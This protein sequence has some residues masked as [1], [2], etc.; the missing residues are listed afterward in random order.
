[1]IILAL[2]TDQENAYVAIYDGRK[3]LSEI[4]WLA[5]RELSTTLFAKID[6]LLN[7][8]NLKLHDIEGIIG[9]EGPG[10]FTGLRIGLTAANTFAYVLDVPIIAKQ[11]ERWLSLGVHALQSGENSKLLLPSYGSEAHITQQKK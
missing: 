4:E 5:H 10:S 11:G 7:T 8:N 6:E 2:K 1:M 3:L 9:F